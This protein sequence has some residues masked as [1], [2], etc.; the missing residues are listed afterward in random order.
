M[1]EISHCQ[2]IPELVNTPSIA[3]LHQVLQTD[4]GCKIG[5]TTIVS[6]DAIMKQIVAAPAAIF[7]RGEATR[8]L[9]FGP[10]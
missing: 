3:L 5:K 10:C 7:S 2:E 9:P 6:V 4:S 1:G 8:T